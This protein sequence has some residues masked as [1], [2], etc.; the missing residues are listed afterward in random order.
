MEINEK[1]KL[2]QRVQRRIRRRKVGSPLLYLGFA[3][4]LIAACVVLK[5]VDLGGK[6]PEYDGI[7]GT[8]AYTVTFTGGAFRISSRIC[9]N[10]PPVSASGSSFGSLTF[11]PPL[12]FG[13][14]A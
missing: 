7:A 13:K 3:A 4:L 5:V 11:R 6:P 12:F 2:T 9:S 10:A 14:R 1:L 8:G